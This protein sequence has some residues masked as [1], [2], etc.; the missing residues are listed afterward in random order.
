ML[1]RLFV[2]KKFEEV[3]KL[4]TKDD[5]NILDVGCHDARIRKFIKYKNYYGVDINKKEINKLVSQ[6]VKATRVDLNRE[7][8]SYNG[9]DYILL[10]DILEHVL[11]PRK[12]MSECKGKLPTNGKIILTLPNDYHILN[13]MRFVFNGKLTKDPFG[14]YGHLHYFSISSAEKELIEAQGFK[15]LKKIIIPPVKPDIIPQIIKNG[16][17]K[18]FPQSFARDILY[19][20]EV[21]K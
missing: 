11:D 15:I 3:A 2:T 1:D 21:R 13:K 4:I 10:L 18:C 7:E 20:I 14:P 19:L 8:I 16:L 17:A 12:L 6:G 5:A 9:F